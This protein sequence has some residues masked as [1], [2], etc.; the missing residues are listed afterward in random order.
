MEEDKDDDVNVD[1]DESTTVDKLDVSDVQDAEDS[2]VLDGE[3][4]DMDQDED[5]EDED[6]ELEDVDMDEDLEPIGGF[7]GTTSSTRTGKGKGVFM[8]VSDVFGNFVGEIFTGRARRGREQPTA[9]QKA[10]PL[11]AILPELS[12]HVPERVDEAVDTGV[13]PSTTDISVSTDNPSYCSRAVS[14]V[15]SGPDPREVEI[16]E[17][18][19]Q[20]AQLKGDLESMRYTLGQRD[21]RV[22]EL[23][24]QLANKQRRLQL[25]MNLH[26]QMDEAVRLLSLT[27]AVISAKP[28]R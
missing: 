1:A 12:S 24:K 5:E 13:G 23:E 27:V 21:E 19:A 16:E 11:D 6:E 14:P 20:V 26:A 25:L 10:Q 7:D 17:L 18:R 22:E 4:E 3:P 2:M 8:R 15:A 28:V 9:D